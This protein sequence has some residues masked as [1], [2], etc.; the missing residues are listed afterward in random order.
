MNDSPGKIKLFD[1]GEDEFMSEYKDD[2]DYYEKPK[3]SSKRPLSK[4]PTATKAAPK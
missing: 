4:K 1:T 3:K 2:D